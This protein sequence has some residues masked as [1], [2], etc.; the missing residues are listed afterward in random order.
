MIEAIL[1]ILSAAADVTKLVDA[2][3]FAAPAD[4]EPRSPYV[5]FAII[6][7]VDEQALGGRTGRI[8]T[9]IQI[10]CWSRNAAEAWRLSRAVV[11]AMV[12]VRGPIAGLV[13]QVIRTDGRRQV[14]EDQWHG[15]SCDFV[16]S[17]SIAA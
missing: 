2:R 7:D 15:V 10:D 9:R 17:Y 16:A 3:I 11:A 4:G 1:P 13:V 12:A 5:T 8:E 14:H 6:D